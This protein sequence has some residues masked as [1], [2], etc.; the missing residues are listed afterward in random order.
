MV[1][2]TG[3]QPAATLGSWGLS[4]LKGSANPEST[5]EAFKFLTSEESQDYLYTK[6]GYTPTQSAVFNDQNL[7]KNHPSLQSIGEALSYARSRPETPLYAQISDVLQRK[8][9]GTLTGITEP[10]VGMQQAE[11]STS[12][13]LEAAGAAP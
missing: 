3:H 2:Q 1:A 10:T 12:Q 9:S 7:L 8:L 13:V 5:V 4:L 11:R 6:F